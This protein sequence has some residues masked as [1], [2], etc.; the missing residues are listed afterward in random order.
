VIPVLAAVV[1][2]VAAVVVVVV[3][4]PPVPAAFEQNFVLV[5]LGLVVED[6]T[7]DPNIDHGASY[8]RQTLRELTWPSSKSDRVQCVGGRRVLWCK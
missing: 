1:V 4:V 7:V 2:A 5:V 8:L 6:S 3:V